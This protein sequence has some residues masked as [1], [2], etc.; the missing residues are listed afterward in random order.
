M[1]TS[2]V[3]GYK[4]V[5]FIAAAAYTFYRSKM[6][7]ASKV[8]RGIYEQNIIAKRRRESSKGKL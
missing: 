3:Y 1:Y 6:D 7:T 4:M 2:Q 8:R 5:I